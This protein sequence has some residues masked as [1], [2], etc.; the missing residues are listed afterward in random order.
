MI[1]RRK[2]QPRGRGR[3]VRQGSIVSKI[4]VWWPR[5]ALTLMVLLAG[6]LIVVDRIESRMTR[7]IRS[8]VADV[9]TPVIAALS[10]PFQAAAEWFSIFKSNAA[11]R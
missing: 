7:E 2:R 11:I 5:I 1:R 4:R 10:T 3:Q 8:G 9:F 6:S